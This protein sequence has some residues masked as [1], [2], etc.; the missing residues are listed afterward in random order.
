MF[1]NHYLKTLAITFNI[2][3]IAIYLMAITLSMGLL[4]WIME[5]WN[6]D[7]R[8]PFSYGGDALLCGSLIKGI[9][10]NGW[11]LHNSFLG[12]PMGQYM[13]D[14]PFS[15]SL[16]FII[17]KL[18]SLFA[19]DYAMS[20]NIYFLLTFPLTTLTSLLVF[21]QF[22]VSYASSILG[23]L[24]FTFVPYHFLR[25]IPHLFL[26]SYYMLPLMIMVILWVMDDKSFLFRSS[27]VSKNLM[28]RKF[29]VSALICILISS[30]FFYYPFFSCFFL[31]VAGIC[32]YISQQNKN[33]LFNSFILISIIILGVLINFS[34]TLIYQHEN[35]KNTEIAIRNPIESEVYGLKIDQ[36]LM[37]ISTHRISFLANL[38]QLYSKKAPLVN[39]NSFASLGLIGSSGFLMLIIWAF[40]R[41]SNGLKLKSY[42]ISNQLAELSIL[43]LSAI[44]L[45]TI[46][47]FGFVFASL[48]SPQIRCYNRISIFIAFFS[49]FASILLIEYFSRKYVKNHT[50]RLLFN[51]FLCFVLVVGVLDQTSGS[52]V[53]SYAQTKAAYLNDKN[54]INNIEAI[55]PE[56][57]MIF[58]LPFVPIPEHSPVKKM[59][60]PWSHLRAYLHSKNLRWS[61]GLMEGRPGNGNDWQKLVA[62]MHV[63]EMLKT[64]SRTGFEGI[65]IDS[66]GFQDGGAKL[67]SDIKQILKTKPLVSGNKRLYFFDMTGYNRRN[68]INLSEYGMT[69]PA[70]LNPMHLNDNFSDQPGPG[71][72]QFENWSGTPTRWMQ[73]NATLPVNSPENRTATLSL[74]A[75]SFYRNRTLEISSCGVPAAQVAVPT[76]FTNLSV[77]IHLTKRANTVRFHVPEGCERPSDKPELNN[78]DKRCLSVAIQNLTVM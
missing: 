69:T 17:I 76:S 54:F 75:H 58:Q 52:F 62:K 10:D 38:S 24:L 19:P 53:P 78:P 32:S 39:E 40:Y 16:D 42:S 63:E 6:A 12:A 66:Y 3:V 9:I 57:A 65:Y 33:H 5:L 35:G 15:N 51:V 27:D 74:N 67:I 59:G 44:L 22:K 47:G 43:N 73:A 49:I 21:R 25:G 29:A 34:P 36:L 37:P 31:V 72:Y 41:I 8:I 46:G 77:P 60:S 61:Y 70:V 30:T 48:I 2:R 50:S 55:M 23:S 20:V 71:F 13:Y 56:N 45:A 14:Y 4:I 18:I 7:L 1:R 68:K 11:Y 64:L 28:T 26:A